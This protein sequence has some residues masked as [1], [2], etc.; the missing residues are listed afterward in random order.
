MKKLLLTG[1]MLVSMVSQAQTWSQKNS[2]FPTASTLVRDMQAVSPTV[3][4]AYAALAG[5]GAP[6]IQEYTKTTDGGATWVSGN[7]NLG[8]TALQISDLTAADAN[9]A[10]VAVNGANQ[11]IWKTSNGGTTWTKQATASFSGAGSFPNT[12]YF[13]DA[14]N[15]VAMGDPDVSGGRFEIYTTSNGGTNWT[16]VPAGNLPATSNEYGYT[17]IKAAAGN[18]IWFGTDL[19]RVM[20]SND[21]GL[22][23]TVI[24]TPILDF[25]GITLP[26]NSG[27]L[28]LKDANT[29]WVMDQDGLLFVTNNAGVNWDLVDVV[30]G[31]VYTGDLK[32]VPGT[33]NTL[34]TGGA[35]LAQRGSS[36]S[37]D[38]GLNWTTLTPDASNTDPGI[39][40][41]AAFNPSTIY[42]G[43][44]RSPSGTGGMNKL[45]ALLATANPNAIKAAVSVY[46]NPTKGQ[47]HIESKSAVKSIV[48]VDMNGRS[49]KTFENM[50]QLDLSGLQKGVYMLNVTL[51]D[52]QKTST[53][54]IKE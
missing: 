5:T 3:A 43:A 12:V 21:K 41:L 18:T 51:A 38:G 9:N 29:A 16:R 53:K 40:A 45:G 20:K 52:G 49:V 48:L 28:T 23:W 13:W 44:F 2:N 15:G 26:G 39:T 10:W 19:G 17:T 36:I 46:P 32:Y 25:G 1:V 8:N 54:L 22:T 47:V 35:S 33:A 31:T 30:S 4:W 11:G 50:K 7:I 14:N 42:G 37:Y 34:I 24:G 6:N 27:S